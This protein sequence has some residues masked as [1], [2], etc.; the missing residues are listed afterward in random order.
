M[1]LENARILD[2]KE[3]TWREGHVLIEA[4]RIKEVSSSPIKTAGARRIDLGGLTLMPGLCDAHVHVTAATASFPE[5]MRWSPMYVAA[6]AIDTMQAMLMR[7][8]TTVRD[9]GGA[10]YGLAMA[11][12]QGYVVGPRLLFSGH[13]ISQ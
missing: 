11:V 1:L 12:E 8:F 6:R 5:L 2:V 13:A 7:G 10:D 3:G 4:G 9:C